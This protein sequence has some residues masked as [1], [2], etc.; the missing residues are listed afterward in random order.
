MHSNGLFLVRV[1]LSALT[2]NGAFEPKS[3]KW[4]IEDVE[5]KGKKKS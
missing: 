1:K 3:I 2:Q 5:V 4:V